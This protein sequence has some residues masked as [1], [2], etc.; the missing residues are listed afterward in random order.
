MIIK[1]YHGPC[2]AAGN[3]IHFFYLIN[4]TREGRFPAGGILC[5]KPRFLTRARSLA[6]RR[7]FQKDYKN[8]K[9]R[10]DAIEGRLMD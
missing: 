1:T 2:I 3:V 10:R 4:E 8:E 6:F 7:R 9:R 5:G